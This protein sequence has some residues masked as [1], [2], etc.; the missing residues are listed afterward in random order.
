V[1]RYLY[2]L[3]LDADRRE[4]VL[5]QREQVGRAA[6]AAAPAIGS[7]TGQKGQTGTN[8]DNGDLPAGRLSRREALLGARRYLLRLGLL[9]IPLLAPY[10]DG[11]SFLQSL[12][13]P[14]PQTES[15]R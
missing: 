1:S 12:D 6:S 3:R 10:Q 4:V 15:Q 8:G 7:A 9:R 14:E 13:A 2:L 11:D 5:I